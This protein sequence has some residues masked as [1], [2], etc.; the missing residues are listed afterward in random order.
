MLARHRTRQPAGAARRRAARFT[1]FDDALARARTGRRLDQHAARHP[2]R[3]R[4][5]GDGGG[6]ARVRR[7][8][9][10]RDGGRRASASSTPP[11]APGESSSSATSSAIIRRGSAS[12]RSRGTLG[13][14]LVFRM[15]LNQQSS[16]AQWER[17]SACCSRFSPIVDCGVHYVDV[18]CQITPAKPV[19]RAR[20]RGASH[21]RSARDV[22]LRPSARHLRRRLG[23]LVRGRLGPDDERDGVLREGRHRPEGIGVDRAWRVRRKP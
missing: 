9:D 17:T 23:R 14:P 4:H 10:R 12:S 18:W 1:S 11:C 16:G 19:A 7:E 5:Q 22:Q 8:A 6:R 15:N 2:R 13:T 20:G 21:R 3:L